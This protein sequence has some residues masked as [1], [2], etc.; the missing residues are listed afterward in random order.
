MHTRVCV[1]PPTLIQVGGRLIQRQD[2]TVEAERLGQ[3]Q[4]D[5]QAGQHLAGRNGGK[6][7]S[8]TMQVIH[9]SLVVVLTRLCIS[10]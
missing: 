1:L 8:T 2:P 5:D 6:R 9:R 7:H 10:H 3:G 4:A